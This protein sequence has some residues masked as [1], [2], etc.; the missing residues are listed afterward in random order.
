[1]ISL[2]HPV[3]EEF[4][5][6]VASSQL[7]IPFITEMDI[8]LTRP[9][10][11]KQIL[12][13]V[14]LKY[15]CD[16]LSDPSLLPD[17]LSR[18]F[19]QQTL[20]YFQMLKGKQKDDEY[21]QKAHELFNS[22][23]NLLKKEDTK[24]KTKIEALEKLLFWPGT[25]IFEKITRS[26]LAQQI[27]ALLDAEGV[28]KLA[29]LYQEVVLAEKLKANTNDTW[30][31]KDRVYAAQLLVKLLSHPSIQTEREWRTEQLK[32]LLNLTIINNNR[33]LNVGTTL[34]GEHK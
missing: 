3:Y 6:A 21:Q 28:K 17:L 26:K 14:I 5:K 29:A 1:M 10:R 11:N 8:S 9:N 33:Y 27:T 32:F 18:N 15:I 20:G 25:F 13:T 34:A 19:I 31:N 7:L 30:W 2:K 16:N 23:L 22:I 12:A 4:A 24:S